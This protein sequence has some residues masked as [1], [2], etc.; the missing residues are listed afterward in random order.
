RSYPNG[1]QRR[2]GY[3]QKIFV[4]RERMINQGEQG[5]RI[6]RKKGTLSRFLLIVHPLILKLNRERL[7]DFGI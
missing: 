5:Q 4:G 6:Y 7:Q 2:V 1:H 3:R